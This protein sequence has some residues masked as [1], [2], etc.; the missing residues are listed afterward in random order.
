M[1]YAAACLAAGRRPLYQSAEQLAHLARAA[2]VVPGA[3]PMKG[4]FAEQH[5]LQIAAPLI[6]K[7]RDEK[8][9]SSTALEEA[10]R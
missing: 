5:G 8:T 9:D 6:V 7:Y 3:R 2:V 10:L 1:A 4:P